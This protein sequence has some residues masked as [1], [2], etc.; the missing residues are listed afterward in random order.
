M[1]GLFGNKKLLNSR[2]RDTGNIIND[3][4]ITFLYDNKIREEIVFSIF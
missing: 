2:G 4:T 1:E 3:K